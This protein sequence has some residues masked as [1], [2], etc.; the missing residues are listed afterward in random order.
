MV[1]V[2]EFV[3]YTEYSMIAPF[4]TLEYKERGIEQYADLLFTCFSAGIIITGLLF[5]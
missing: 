3:A 4:V 5:N 1:L 2:N